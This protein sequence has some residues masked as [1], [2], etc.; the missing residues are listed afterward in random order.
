MAQVLL[1]TPVKKELDSLASFFGSRGYGAEVLDCRVP[2]F[3]IET[4]SLVCAAAGH[5]KAQFAI[6]TQYIVDSH[7]PFTAIVA[8]GVAGALDKGLAA[9]DVVVGTESIEHDYKPRFHGVGPPP[10]HA[11]APELV[12]SIRSAEPGE[13]GFR[14]LTGPI[15]GGDEDIISPAR[16]ENL[17]ELTGALCVAWEGAGGARAAK[18]ND[19]PF[20]EIRAVSDAADD[21]ASDDYKFNLE[22]SMTNLGILLLRWLETDRRQI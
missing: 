9:G 17:K 8:A 5:G 3:T 14:V 20:V 1:V 7:G 19:I 6:G 4:L 10:R 11:S 21:S 2:A 13:T 15:A 22:A 16:A 12:A 18:F